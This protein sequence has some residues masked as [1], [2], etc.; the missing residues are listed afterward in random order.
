MPRYTRR[1][2]VPVSAE[3]L[4]DWHL[5]YGA[6]DRLTPPWE[7]AQI[8]DR[9][10]GVA[11]GSRATIRVKTPLGWKDWVAEHRGIIPGREFQDVQISGPF[12]SWTHTHRML[13]ETATTSQYE[14]DIE[15][16]LPMGALGATFGSGMAHE[17]LDRMFAYRHRVVNADL[18]A[19]ARY[20]GPPL[21]VL[22]SGATGLVGK[23]LSAFLTTGGHTVT[24]LGRSGTP[25]RTATEIR[26]NP[27]VGPVTVEHFSGFDAVIHLAGESVAGSRWTAERK[28]RI[29][30][31]R[32]F[33]TRRLCEA[34]AQAEVKPK[35]LV[36]ASAIGYYGDRGDT[37]LTEEVGPGT[38]FLPEVCVEWEQACDP[39]RKAGIRVI[40]LRIG[41]VLSPLGGA[42]ET[43]LPIFNLGGGGVLGNG[44][45][46]MPCI[47]L[48]DLIY[49]IHHGLITPDLAGPV[50]GVSPTPV[51]NYEF[52]K[53]LGKVIGRPT[54]VP[55]PQF[56]AR[57]AFGELSDALLFA[58][59]RVVPKR[60]EETGFA[61]SYPT[62]DASLRHVL[63]RTV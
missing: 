22:M 3:T 30:D 35:V 18:S 61:F 45:Q 1:S 43:M 32:L 51:T 40:N 8:V 60:L 19:H 28:R 15:Y 2:P 56:G 55:V 36:C 48:D 41:V 6:I 46:Y 37:V 39:A 10:Q 4:F 42:L 54:L 20:P 25:S 47:A 53:T 59:S 12:A 23:N 58:S 29:R 62:L 5:R 38:G 49:A 63:G 44:R 24:P 26:W 16:V 50:N 52:T 31:S 13:P 7:E 9:G 57:L 34:L 33:G 11:E 17:K 14:D 21:Q 27:E